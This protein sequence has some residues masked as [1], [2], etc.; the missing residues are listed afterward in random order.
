MKR[1]IQTPAVVLKNSRMGEMHKIV[2]M[3]TPG[4]GIVRGI[5]H[6]AYRGRNRF[7]GTTDPYTLIKAYLY[8]EPVKNSWKFTDVEVIH[9]NDNIKRE[10]EKL[11]RAALFSETILVSHGGGEQSNVFYTLLKETLAYLDSAE[12]RSID[13]L[14]LQFVWRFLLYSGTKPELNSC[15]TCGRII[16]VEESAFYSRREGNFVCGTCALEGYQEIT[17]GGRAFLNHIE[18]YTLRGSISTT[19]D[20]KSRLEL[21]RI[22]LRFLQ[23]NLEYNLK[24]LMAGDLFA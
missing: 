23:D 9:S 5:A 15:G 12:Q 3:L 22:L 16:S 14:V 2:H 13:N 1:N 11:Q 8:V 7:S 6:G 19:L 20:N 21:K 18:S 17:P 10:I 4:M 24:S